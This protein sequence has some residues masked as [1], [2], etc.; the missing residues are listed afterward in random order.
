MPNS[1]GLRKKKRHEK[2][3]LILY[4]VG[5]AAFGIALS[6][7]TIVLY[8]NCNQTNPKPELFPLITLFNYIHL[9]QCCYIYFI[10]FRSENVRKSF[11]K[12]L[13]KMFSKNTLTNEMLKDSMSKSSSYNPNDDEIFNF[14]EVLLQIQ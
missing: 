6:I 4:V 9:I 1:I 2:Q 11:K 13:K 7:I 3:I 8:L 5:Y 10:I 14:E 12:F